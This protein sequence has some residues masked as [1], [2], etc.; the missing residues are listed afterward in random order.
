M[1]PYL[2]LIIIAL[3]V[4]SV[5]VAQKEEK[6]GKKIVPPDA[7]KSAFAKAFPVS[8]NIR[9][10]KE[11]ANYEAEFKQNGKTM[12]A[13]FDEKGS[14]LETESTIKAS[15]LPAPVLQYVKDHYKGASIKEASKIAKSGGEVN[16]EAEVNEA[17]LIFD[18][19]GKFIREEKG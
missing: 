14:L 7:A 2:F 18:A 8:S 10:N 1:K 6:E 11:D 13:A 5:C 3:G 16:Y 19:N 15:E 17:D 12:S 4:S 9:W